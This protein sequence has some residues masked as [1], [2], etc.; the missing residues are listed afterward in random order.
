MAIAQW[1]HVGGELAGA[2]DAAAAAAAVAEEA[3][4]DPMSRPNSVHSH[5]RARLLPSTRRRRRAAR[6]RRRRVT[7]PSCC[8]RR[9]TASH[10]TLSRRRPTCSHRSGCTACA[11]STPA[12]MCTGRRVE[13]SSF[14]PPPSLWCTIPR[15]MRSASSP[16]TR[17][18]CSALPSTQAGCSPPPVRR[19]SRRSP[20]SGT[21]DLEA[22]SCCGV[23]IGSA[24]VRLPSTRAAHLATAGLEPSHNVA[25]GTGRAGR[26]S[27][28][29]RG[30]RAPLRPRLPPA[31]R[32]RRRA[33]DRTRGVRRPCAPLRIL[34][35]P[36]PPPAARPPSAPA[37][38]GAPRVPRARC[39]AS[40][41]CRA[42]TA[43][44]SA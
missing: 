4:L 31:R 13:R 15:R 42:A 17:M 27:G 20:A 18:T 5:A 34:W 6:R 25:L 40:P 1:R 29:W 11:P 26:S 37:R 10:S 38:R 14:M 44:A 2:D 21:R 24:S 22:L 7:S 39:S 28:G 9:R 3:A 35:T 32:R 12:R 30:P 41:T 8:R 16:R 33:G 23:P 19:A 36:T 43:A